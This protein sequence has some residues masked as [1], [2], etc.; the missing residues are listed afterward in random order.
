VSFV[1]AEMTDFDVDDDRGR[2]KR[3]HKPSGKARDNAEILAGEEFVPLG[4]TSK[5][6]ADV[7][8]CL[9]VGFDIHKPFNL[10]NYL[11]QKTRQ[12]WTAEHQNGIYF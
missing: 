11:K 3:S 4:S 9:G 1:N 10:L 8:K 12:S 7:L 5:W 6:T 2:P